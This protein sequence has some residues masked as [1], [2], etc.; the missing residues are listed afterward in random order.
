VGKRELDH[1][2]KLLLIQEN[3]VVEVEHSLRRACM[4]HDGAHDQNGPVRQDYLA[5]LQASTANRR[6]P[7]EFD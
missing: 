4:E 3:G 5:R 2:E 7:L 6:H 1:Q